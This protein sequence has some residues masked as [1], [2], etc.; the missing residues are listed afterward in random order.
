MNSLNA[1]ASWR[2][3]LGRTADPSKQD[4]VGD[5]DPGLGRADVRRVFPCSHQ[6]FGGL[7]PG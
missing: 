1:L 7:P 2:Y 5:D 6:I 4:C 3:W